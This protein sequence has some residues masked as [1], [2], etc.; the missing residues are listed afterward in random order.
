M[1]REH[2]PGK[3]DNFII[4]LSKHLNQGVPNPLG[5]G[6]LPAVAYSELGRVNG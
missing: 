4:M 5:G 6:P 1:I 3:W 2:K